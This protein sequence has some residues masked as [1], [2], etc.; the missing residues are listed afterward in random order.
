MNYA[1]C[2]KIG[3]YLNPFFDRSGENFQK[4]IFE[5]IKSIFKREVRMYV[6]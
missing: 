5:I 1:T 2:V 3:M 4:Y 6:E